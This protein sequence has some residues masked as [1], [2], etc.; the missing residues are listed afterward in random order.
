MSELVV[1][2]VFGNAEGLE[3]LVERGCA[4]SYGLQK[5]TLLLVRDDGVIYRTGHTWVPCY[6]VSVSVLLCFV[7]SL[8]GCLVVVFLYEYLV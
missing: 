5:V 6:A 2:V 8:S 7:R 3:A 4:S 1:Y